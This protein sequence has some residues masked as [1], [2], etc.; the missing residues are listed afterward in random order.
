MKI[1]REAWFFLEET[2]PP[3]CCRSR[4]WINTPKFG[5]S[6]HQSA[7]TCQMVL[8]YIIHVII[9]QQV[10]KVSKNWRQE[11]SA[12]L[13]MLIGWINQHAT[14]KW[15]LSVLLSIF[16]IIRKKNS[17]H[18]L[19]KKQELEPPEKQTASKTVCLAAPG[20]CFS[21]WADWLSSAYYK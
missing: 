6:A 10:S 13:T 14:I 17:V 2:P 20:M 1:D 7:C 21:L 12:Y 15:A 3:H 16:C 5:P 11:T 9:S 18:K 4:P 8:N 19:C